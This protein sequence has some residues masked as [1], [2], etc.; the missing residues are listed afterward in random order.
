LNKHPSFEIAC[1]FARA[2][3]VYAGVGGIFKSIERESGQGST[4]FG[5]M[6]LSFKDYIIEQ[7]RPDEEDP[8]PDEPCYDETGEE[9][10]LDVDETA[11]MYK[12]RIMRRR[13]DPDSLQVINEF[14]QVLAQKVGNLVIFRGEALRKFRVIFKTTMQDELV[15]PIFDY[16]EMYGDKKL[17]HFAY[18]ALCEQHPTMRKFIPKD[19][20]DIVMKEVEKRRKWDAKSEE[21][22]LEIDNRRPLPVAPR[23]HKLVFKKRIALSMIP[24]DSEVA[25]VDPP[26]QV[27]EPPKKKAR[28]TDSDLI[29]DERM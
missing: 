13:F 17:V 12:D 6:D 8:L 2:P 20:M 11:E 22:R 26:Q 1:G 4:A 3:R 9:K 5:L 18:H 19:S 7:F 28:L 27:Q 23:R 21:R 29:C 15:Q 10:S 25:F 14:S 24:E 16:L